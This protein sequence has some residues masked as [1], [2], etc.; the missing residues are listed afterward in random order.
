V[1]GSQRRDQESLRKGPGQNPEYDT[2][3]GLYSASSRGWF[4]RR[5]GGV[6]VTEVAVWGRRAGIVTG[7]VSRVACPLALNLICSVRAWG[8]YIGLTH[9][10]KRREK[11][12]V[13]E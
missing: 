9:E 8:W 7:R 11:G 3:V 4:A 10:L 6:D 2:F 5:F 12:F 1:R 13:G